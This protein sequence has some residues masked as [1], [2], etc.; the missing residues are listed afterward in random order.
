MKLSRMNTQASDPIVKNNPGHSIRTR[1]ESKFE[2]E[3]AEKAFND[4]NQ[5]IKSNRESNT[6]NKF[7]M[8]A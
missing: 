8:I 2:P 4:F 1:N 3:G 6:S 5:A 7:F